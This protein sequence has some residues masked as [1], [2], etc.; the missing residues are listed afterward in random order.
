MIDSAVAPPLPSAISFGVAPANFT[1]HCRALCS[2][3]A[4][5]LSNILATSASCGS[6]GSG[7]E[8]SDWREIRADLMVRTG[9]HCDESV[10]RQIAPC[11]VNILSSTCEK[12]DSL[13]ES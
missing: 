11:A 6:F 10:S 2:N 3:S 12:V 8:R 1:A 9:D 5:F 13:S 7:V 4:G